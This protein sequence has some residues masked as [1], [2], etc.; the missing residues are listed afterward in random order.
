MWWF[1]GPAF[2]TI[3][4]MALLIHFKLRPG[5]QGDPGR[6]DRAGGHGDQFIQA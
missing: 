3:V 4:F 5:V 6:R 1:F 2:L